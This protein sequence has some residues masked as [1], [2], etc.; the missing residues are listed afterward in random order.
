MGIDGFK[1]DYGED[2]VPSIGPT[3]NRWSFSDGSDERTM[4]HRFSG[5]YHRVYADA[6]PD[7]SRRAV[8]PNPSLP[9]HAGTLG[10]IG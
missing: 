9:F 8:N 7:A 3:A 10:A 2:I 5:L 4:H 6:A 1:L